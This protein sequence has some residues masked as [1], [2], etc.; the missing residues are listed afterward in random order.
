MLLDQLHSPTANPASVQ[1]RLARAIA[2]SLPT[3]LVATAVAAPL[4]LQ[5]PLSLPRLTPFSAA[6][7]QAVHLSQ[8]PTNGW[9]NAILNGLQGGHPVLRLAAAGGLLLGFADKS[10]AIPTRA[11]D[12]VVIALA[13][14]MAMYTSVDWET[15]SSHDALAISLV[16]A[17][18]SLPL[19]APERLKALP[20]PTLVNLLTASLVFGFTQD[21][22][23]AVSPISKLTALCLSL[24]LDSRP[25]DG[26]PT[27]HACLVSLRD[28]AATRAPKALLFATVMISNAVLS[29]A[30]YIPPSVYSQ[31]DSTTPASLAHTTLHALSHMSSL[32][33]G[34]GGI[35]STSTDTFAELRQ[36]TYL[37]LDILAA[38][39][40][41]SPDT[42]AD[43][44]AFV[45]ELLSNTNHSL[46]DEHY[47]A[48]TLACMEQLV[49]ALSVECIIDRVWPVV[50][51]H[52]SDSTHRQVYESAHSVVLAIFAKAS[53]SASTS[54][55]I[56]FDTGKGKGK[57]TQQPPQP[58]SL[59]SFTSTLIP[60]YIRSLVYE[61]S[62]SD[63]T[64]DNGD[65]N[66]EKLNTIQLS[67]AFEACVRRAVGVD[68]EQHG[69]DG[70]GFGV[71]M[72]RIIL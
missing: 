59:T 15:H 2:D 18:Q 13:Q 58:Q 36:T 1:P 54:P 72:F 71:E 7:R 55:K 50:E 38:P 62:L 66:G 53:A 12:H 4:F 16:L 57:E 63:A 29:S 5:H 8:N 21:D 64:T 61:N 70:V 9:V 46:S 6:F 41:G 28:L 35:S 11:Q 20:L 69:Y 26:L 24:L 42:H 68:N 56:D 47:L 33:A 14:V 10:R 25:K 32:I 40:T 37:A 52:L 19:I 67:M 60:F 51:Q 44:D 45:N 39:T 27:A 43:A 23:A 31:P 3:S 49:P 30:V 17:S 48:F 34:F 65:G 22:L